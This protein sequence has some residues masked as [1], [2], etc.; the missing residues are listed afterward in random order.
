MAAKPTGLSA[1]SVEPE[2]FR[3]KSPIEQTQE[4]L[5]ELGYYDGPVNGNGNDELARAIRKYESLHGMA[6]TGKVSRRLLEHM[7]NV[8]RVQVLIRRLDEVRKQGQQ[9][10]RDALMSNPVTRELLE[11]NDDQRADPTRDSSLC[12]KSPDSVCLLKEAVESSRAVYEDDLRDWAL[13][14]ILAAQVR[15]GLEDDAMKTAAR[16]KDT[17]LVIAALTKIAKTHARDGKIKEAS[18][19]LSL[20]P[21]GE[22]RI[23]VLLEIAAVHVAQ[24]DVKALDQV[25]EQALQEIRSMEDA[26]TV[27]PFEI[28]VAILLARSDEKRALELLEDVAKR[29]NRDLVNGTR[30]SMLRHVA[31]AMAQVGFPEWALKT[32]ET[33][34]DG[35]NR[36]PILMAATRAFL[37]KERF[38]A[39]QNTLQRITVA[40]Y[41]SV[42]MADA[43]KAL[44]QGGKKD[45]AHEIL[46]EAQTVAESIK[47]PFA[48]NFAVSKVAEALILFA[49]ET[50]EGTQAN[51]AF[52]LLGSISD[53]RMRARGLWDL[54]RASQKHGFQVRDND[55]NEAATKAIADIRSNFSR[56]WILG[57]LVKEHTEQGEEEMARKAMALG[58]ETARNLSNPWARS[59]ALAKFGA[60]MNRLH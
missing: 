8:G 34:P 35:D 46:S 49:S 39:A 14:E 5:K 9:E 33:L 4:L 44:W 36:V 7:E 2:V 27:I 42:I 26:E 30:L 24:Q 48:R 55:V 13:G 59:R 58:L 31:S 10:A 60:L 17:R 32:M 54:A 57:D 18:S 21:V 1:P 23:S 12:F 3:L 16:I 19:S 53:D 43:A 40:R 11:E 20:I 37:E 45:R 47:L 29:A 22:R 25:I 52:A 56:A 15:A 38:E 28:K 51:R 6:S 41:R 50:H